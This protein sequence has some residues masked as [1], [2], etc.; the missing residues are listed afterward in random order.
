MANVVNT[1]ILVD[2]PRN[3]VVKVTGQLTASDLAYVTFLDPSVLAGIDNSLSVKAKDFQ[4]K[5][6]E[7]SIEDPLTVQLYWDATTPV[8]A[9]S[10]TGRGKFPSEEYGGIPTQ[11][12]AGDTGKLGIATQGFTTGSVI[13]FSFVLEVFKVQR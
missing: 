7:Y 3:T 9:L 12:G 6:I 5:K 13:N 2:G 8:L 10:A 4:I 11:A 1:Q